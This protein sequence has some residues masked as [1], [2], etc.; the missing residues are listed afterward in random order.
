MY[1]EGG[2]TYPI[3]Y[4]GLHSTDGQFLSV[5]ERLVF[6]LLLN[7]CVKH[8]LL[9]FVL[10]LRHEDFHGLLIHILLRGSGDAIKSSKSASCYSIVHVK[11]WYRSAFFDYTHV[12][13]KNDR[14]FHRGSGSLSDQPGIRSKSL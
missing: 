13:L 12:R 5:A 8:G 6:P 4:L 10:I 3:C 2:R 14:W 9:R 1:N 7:V 11:S